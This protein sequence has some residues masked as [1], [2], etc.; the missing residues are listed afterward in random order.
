MPRQLTDVNGVARILLF[1]DEKRDP[2]RRMVY[3][4]FRRSHDPLPHRKI[5]K[6]LRLVVER[7]WA[8]IDGQP[9]PD[10][11]LADEAAEAGR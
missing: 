3:R 8:W 11:R 9:G 7:V 6:H 2:D 4:L 10:K 5:G 1:L